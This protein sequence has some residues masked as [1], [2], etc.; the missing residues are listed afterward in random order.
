M[1]FK[2]FQ[3]KS[4]KSKSGTKD[5]KSTSPLAGVLATHIRKKKFGGKKPSKKY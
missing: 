5:A 4:S 3:K 1:A 2:L